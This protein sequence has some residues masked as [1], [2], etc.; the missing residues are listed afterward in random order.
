M[1]AGLTPR[2]IDALWERMV[3]I[4]G[5]RW[6]DNFGEADDGTWLVGLFD[7]KPEDIARGL[8]RCRTRESPWPP[9]LPEF[10]AMCKPVAA[11]YHRPSPR[12]PRPPSNPELADRELNKMKQLLRKSNP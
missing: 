10:R 4:Y 7:V 6:T 1:P 5:R 12:I 9:T 3:R 2:H 11:P 8:D